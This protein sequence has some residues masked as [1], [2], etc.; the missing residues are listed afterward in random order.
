MGTHFAS[1]PPLRLSEHEGILVV[2]DDEVP[3]GTKARV[4]PAL[5]GEA[6]TEYVYAS[7][8]YGYAQ[9]ALAYTAAALGKRA[10]IFCAQ[11]KQWHART[12]EAHAAG[13]TI[14]EVPVGYLSVVQA[15]A[16]A[17]CAMTR[18]AYLPFGF[19][20]P[21]FCASL[22]ALAQRLPLVPSEVWAVAGS[23]V[24]VR[25]LHQAWPAARVHAIQVGAVPTIGSATLYKAPERFE[26][27]AHCPPPFPSCSNY[28]AKAWRFV[29]AHATPGA[30]FWN[31]AR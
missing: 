28:D 13:A 9:I 7:P 26:Q 10:T 29:R 25:A 5:L 11:R 27:D 2:R 8:V 23:G 1:L 19:D 24:L 12:V 22:V 18:A 4:L 31:V 30:L 21:A 15:R 14:V 16:R 6:A 17:Y 3:G 20:T